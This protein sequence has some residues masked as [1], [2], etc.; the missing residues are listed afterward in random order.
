MCVWLCRFFIISADGSGMEL[1][2]AKDVCEY[3]AEACSDPA[4]AVLQDPVQEQPGRKCFFS[5]RL[6][7]ERI[8]KFQNSYMG[9]KCFYLCK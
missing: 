4:T 8:E 5:D 2:R 6:L 9:R 7:I 3:M 1:L